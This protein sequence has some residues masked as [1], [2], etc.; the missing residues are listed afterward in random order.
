MSFK[1]ID[2]LCLRLKIIS[3]Q[4]LPRPK[5][6]SSK[7]SSID[8]YVTVQLFGVPNDCAEVRTRTVSNGGHSP[9]FD[10]SF[11][12][13]IA[14]PELS[15]IRFLVLDDDYIN[16]D[17]IGQFTIPIECIQTGYKH[18]RLCSLGG[19]PLGNATLFVH[20]SL[21][22]RFSSKQK[23]R[24]KRSWSNKQSTEMRSIGIKSI[25]EQF[26]SASMLIQ[27]SMQLRK[28]AEKAMIDLSDECCLS[29]SANMAQCLRVITLR[30]A[31]CQS[32]NS[33]E[34]VTTEQGVR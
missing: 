30:L 4:Q 32:V 9:L 18:V 3:G 24:R 14:V 27:E 12:F 6:A 26:K 5:G 8:P 25:D 17:F 16:D 1:G 23:L 28:T 10:E 19:D 13:N 33:C 15:L 34:I 20:I 2:P 21:T 22:R 29:E 11:E 7:A 31:S